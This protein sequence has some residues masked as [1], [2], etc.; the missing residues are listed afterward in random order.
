MATIQMKRGQKTAWET[1]NPVLAAG[2][3]GLVM[4]E[5]KMYFGDGTK[6]YTELAEDGAW[7]E[8]DL[9]TVGAIDGG[10]IV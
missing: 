10:E 3:C 2:E 7:N 8:F 9:E 4:D 5:K 1:K 6:T